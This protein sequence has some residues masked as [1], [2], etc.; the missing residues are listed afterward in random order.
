MPG[1][2]T[3]GTCPASKTRYTGSVT[4][5]GSPHGTALAAVCAEAAEESAPY[6]KES[7]APVHTATR[8]VT[9]RPAKQLQRAAHPVSLAEFKLEDAAAN[10]LRGKPRQKKSR[11]TVQASRQV[12]ATPRRNEPG[13]D[14]LA[15]AHGDERPAWMRDG[16]EVTLLDGNEDLEVVGES[17]YQEN[18]WRLVSPRRRGERVR[19]EVYAMLV[20]EDANPYDA[21]AVAVWVQG[22]K[23]GHLPR[24]DACR[25]RPGL[26]RL[27]DR[28][29]HPI[30]LAGMIVGGGMHQDG[31]G[32][33]A[34]SSATTQRTSGYEPTRGSGRAR[35]VPVSTVTRGESRSIT[36]QPAMV[37][38]CAAAGTSAVAT[39]FASRGSGVRVSLAPPGKHFAG[40]LLSAVDHQV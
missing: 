22:L 6:R 17:F 19:C 23:A 8:A 13:Q 30:A 25:Y 9:P 14:Q 28:Y 38:T 40:I 32:G 21:S 20:P 24:G 33:L 31:P 5:T 34:Y 12:P 26:F 37:L 39:S 1:W 11:N 10:A 35:R 18:L 29:G 7:H 2:S 4:R 3:I 15:V 36:E 27:Q 16:I